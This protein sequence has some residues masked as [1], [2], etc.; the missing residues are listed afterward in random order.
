MVYEGGL[1]IYTTLDPDL[2]EMASE[3]VDSIVNPEAGDPSASLVSIDPS[4]GASQGDGRRLGLRRGEVQPRDPGA[5]AGGKLV[6]ALRLRRGRARG[7]LARD[8]VHL[9]A[10]E[11]RH[12]QERKALRGGQLR[13]HPPRTRSRCRRRWPTRT[14]PSSSSSPSTSGFRRWWRWPTSSAWTARST[15]TRRPRSGASG[16][17]LRRWRWP[18]PTR[19]SPTRARTWS[20]TWSRR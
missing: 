12:G 3:A 9:Q 7:D 4:T 1:K 19:L 11:H 20:L 13:L 14:T 5:Q 18:R 16:S 17:G 8:H 6:Q 2:Q 15:P 10:P